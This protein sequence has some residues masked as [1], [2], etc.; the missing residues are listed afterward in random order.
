M[1]IDLQQLVWHAEFP[2]QFMV[3]CFKYILIVLITISHF[4]ASSLE[5][6]FKKDNLIY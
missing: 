6:W 1:V 2:L 3:F 4:I 5:N